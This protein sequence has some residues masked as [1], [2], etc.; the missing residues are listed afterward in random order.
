MQR[1]SAPPRN[2]E[3]QA[4]AAQTEALLGLRVLGVEPVAAGLGARRFYRLRTAGHPPSLLARVEAG[5]DAAGRPAGAA[6]EPPLPPILAL[7]AQAGL[8]VPRLCGALPKL[9]AL[10]L[11][12]GGPRSLCGLAGENPASARARLA[13]VVDCIPRLQRIRAETGHTACPV[14]AFGRRLNAELFAYKAELF[15]DWSLPLALG[16]AATAGERDALRGGFAQIAAE[17]AVAP[18]RLAHRDL[19]SRNVLTPGG[20]ILLIDLQGAFMA[21]PEYDLVCLLRD[22]YVDWG[23]AVVA[24]ELARV[25]PQL[26]DAPDARTFA[27]R[28]EL[29]TLA[30]KGKDHARFLSAAAQRGVAASAGDLQR[31]V[32]ALQRAAQS[33]L[34]DGAGAP[35]GPGGPGARPALAPLLRWILAL[36]EHAPPS[37]RRAQPPQPPQRLGAPGAA[38]RG[39]ADCGR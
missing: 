2:A 8:P 20:G 33:L 1:E 23:E 19:Q 17:C 25:R 31:S 15:A 5:E 18:L 4:L 27:R 6:P 36:P 30:R 32:R 28:F 16:R 3:M 7:L 24:E 11:E 35:D 22:S 9:G 37:Q 38:R 14:A 26:P 39:E 21:P 12:D 13:A 10:L 29:L 34:A